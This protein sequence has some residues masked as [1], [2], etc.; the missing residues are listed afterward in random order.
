VF[1]TGH[2]GFKGG[3]L[4]L[5]LNHMGAEVYGY[6]LRPPLG[7]SFFDAAGL[8]RRIDGQFADIRDLDALSGAMVAFNPTVVIHLAAQALVGEGYAD[9]VGTFSTN[10]MGTVNVLEAVRQCGERCCT[11]IITTD[12]V[13]E[14]P[15]TG[16]GFV[17]TD[18]LGGRDPYAASKACAE[19]SVGAYH[20]AFLAAREGRTATARAGNIIGGGDFATDRLLPDL[21]SAFA[22]GE[23]GLVRS[24]L[25]VRPWQ[26]VLDPLAGYLLAI[27]HLA[28]V[29][30]P[31]LRHWNFG[32]ESASCVTVAE[33]AERAAVAWG[34][35]AQWRQLSVPDAPHEARLLTLDA[36]RARDDLDWR[37][38]IDVTQAIDWTISWA[39]AHMAG[40]PMGA[41]S[42][43]QISAYCE[44]RD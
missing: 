42:L 33:L 7:P 37:G 9:P 25:S 19:L 27:E 3:W 44:E 30:A 26:H 2:T 40:T 8:S 38:R 13:Y 22:R 11:L 18:P 12:K 39:R 23:A 16:R 29:Q 4:A 36:S 21:L 24:P 14:N 41:F 17:E 5:W 1:L 35:G 20:H 32:P 6:A 28:Q 15:E 43:Q 10:L 31:V 34:Q